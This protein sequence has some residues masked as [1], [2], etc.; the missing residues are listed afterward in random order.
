MNF[1]KGALQNTGVGGLE[2]VSTL[3]SGNSVAESGKNFA[4]RAMSKKFEK[5]FIQA[6]DAYASG[7]SSTNMA[8]LGTV[9]ISAAVSGVVW[10]GMKGV[11]YLDRLKDEEDQSEGLEFVGALAHFVAFVLFAV[12]FVIMNSVRR[13]KMLSVLAGENMASQYAKFFSIPLAIFF[14][15]LRVMIPVESM[16][17]YQVLAVA[18]ILAGVVVGIAKKFYFVYKI[19]V[20]EKGVFES[21]AAAFDACKDAGSGVCDHEHA[22]F[23]TVFNNLNSVLQANVRQVF[24][25]VDYA[26]I[27]REISKSQK[28]D[29]I[30]AFT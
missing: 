3:A 19:N 23:L 8:L 28:F 6:A 12:V 27:A 5:I 15:G 26:E 2:A 18:S 10:G 4:K 9:G 14:V 1:L 22:G 17:T 20:L 11:A 7:Y 21:I 25:R 30:E 13:Q 24:G 16:K 29:T